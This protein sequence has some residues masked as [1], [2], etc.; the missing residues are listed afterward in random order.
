MLHKT[1]NKLHASALYTNKQWL[2]QWIA[3]LRDAPSLLTIPPSSRIHTQVNFWCWQD[4]LATYPSQEL[5]QFFLKGLVQGFRM[6]FNNSINSDNCECRDYTV[7]F[8]IQQVLS[9]HMHRHKF[10]SWENNWPPYVQCAPSS[11]IMIINII[12]KNKPINYVCIV[13]Y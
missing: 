6:G 10:T 3:H 7:G 1:T 9:Q 5:V 11:I 8:E 2:P 12:L 13:T 4:Y